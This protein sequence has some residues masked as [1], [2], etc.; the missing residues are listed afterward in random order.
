MPHS[1]NWWRASRL[2][3]LLADLDVPLTDHLVLARERWVSMRQ[4]AGELF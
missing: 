4:V 1:L 2:A 3:S